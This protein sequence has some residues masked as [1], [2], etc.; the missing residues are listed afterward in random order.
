VRARVR[1]AHNARSAAIPTRRRRAIS[2]ILTDGGRRVPRVRSLRARGVDDRCSPSLSSSPSL[3]PPPLSLSP[4]THG[5]SCRARLSIMPIDYLPMSI[6][7]VQL[8]A[9]DR[10]TSFHCSAYAADKPIAAAADVTDAFV[11]PGTAV[12]QPRRPVYQRRLE[13][14]FAIMHRHGINVAIRTGSSSALHR[15]RLRIVDR[16]RRRS[17]LLKRCLLRA[18]INER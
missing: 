18:K 15:S 16:S 3:P 14:F 12:P 10:D 17:S 6:G 11:R 5:T 4:S 7:I 2:W 8:V 13:S 9:R 1:D